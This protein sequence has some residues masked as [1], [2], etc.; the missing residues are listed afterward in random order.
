MRVP[1][2]GIRAALPYIAWA[3][4]LVATSGSLFLS[5]VLGYP[6]C[7][8]CWY[9]RIAMYPLVAIIAVA[10]LRRDARLHLYVL[11]LSLVGLA[12]ALYHNLLYIGV[13]PETGTVC[14]AGVSC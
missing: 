7:V 10:I 13:I 12:I 5:E 14:R 9:Q 6:P 3:Q 8:L 2:M 1:V 11:P 4:A